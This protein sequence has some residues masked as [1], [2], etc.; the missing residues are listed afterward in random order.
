M[1]NDILAVVIPLVALAIVFAWVPFLNLVC[2][3]CVNSLERRAFREDELK[4][5]TS[6]GSRQDRMSY[7]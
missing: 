5:R 6:M 3:P 2:P 1:F 4:A 7:R